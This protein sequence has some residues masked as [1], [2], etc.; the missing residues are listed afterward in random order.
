MRIEG[1]AVGEL[2]ARVSVAEL[3]T[4]RRGAGHGGIHMQPHVV[5]AADA[6]NLWQRVDGIGRRG[7][8]GGAD[9]AGNQSS[10]AIGFNL[11][12]QRIRAHGKV[13]VDFDQT[14]MIEP[15]AGNLDVLLDGRVRLSRSVND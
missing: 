8:D 5:L 3:G 10:L 15:H 2:D 4:K 7:T 14:Q 12:C 9:K 13:L 11:L 6:A 1:V